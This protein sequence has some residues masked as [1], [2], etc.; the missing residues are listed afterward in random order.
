MSKAQAMAAYEHN[1]TV[2]ASIAEEK[3]AGHTTVHAAKVSSKT[4]N[5]TVSHV[6]KPAKESPRRPTTVTHGLGYIP[7]KK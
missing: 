7:P 6:A 4:T 2:A 5:A 1:K 3:P